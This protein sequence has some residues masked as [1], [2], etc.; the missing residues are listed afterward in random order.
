MIVSG[1]LR[2]AELA[3]AAYAESGADA[4]MLARGSLGNPWVF[5]ELT[6]RRSAPPA[7]DEIVRELLWVVDRAEEHFGA[8]RAA[9]YLRKFYP[10]YL[11][12]L[13]EPRRAREPFQR[14]TDLDEARRLVRALADPAPEAERGHAAAPAPALAYS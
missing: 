7:R 6:G 11:D 3:R 5:E 8:Q 1:G 2:S 12:R 10:W 14:T 9:P 13:G 4:V